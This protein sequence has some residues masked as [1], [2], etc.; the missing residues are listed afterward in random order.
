MGE[1][2]RAWSGLIVAHAV[3]ITGRMRRRKGEQFTPE[4]IWLFRELAE[5]SP[6]L[7]KQNPHP[8]W[9][10]GLSRNKA[11]EA[12]KMWRGTR[13]HNSDPLD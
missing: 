7:R 2:G 4:L 3:E 6:N 11:G 5:L 8:R 10:R 9:K 1:A 12:H 13:H